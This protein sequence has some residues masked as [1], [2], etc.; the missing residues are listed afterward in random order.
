MT[1]REIEIL[2]AEHN[3][4]VR[5]W[6]RFLDGVND[7]CGNVSAGEWFKLFQLAPDFSKVADIIVTE[8]QKEGLAVNYDAHSGRINVIY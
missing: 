3:K 5:S 6:E 2:M 4:L 1:D 7:V 8:A